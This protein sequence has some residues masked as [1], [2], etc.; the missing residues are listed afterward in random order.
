[1]NEIAESPVAGLDSHVCE[2]AVLD[3]GGDTGAL[4]IYADEKM[5]GE[6]IEI[7]RPGD[8]RSRCHNVVRARRAPS[9][10]VYAA[11]FPALSDGSYEV[12]DTEGSP[13]RKANVAGGRVTEI[14]CCSA[15]AGS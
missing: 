10:L 11:V 2:T 14:D 15:L 12:L 3:I 5:V 9:G 1:M 6:E 7:C 4:I 8:L 13:C